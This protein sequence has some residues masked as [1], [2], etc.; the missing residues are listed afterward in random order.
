MRRSKRPTL[1]VAEL[2][3]HSSNSR[4]ISGKLLKVPQNPQF[5]DD[6]SVSDESDIIKPSKMEKQKFD[7]IEWYMKKAKE[8]SYFRC[9]KK[10]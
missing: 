4:N 2:N 8:H 6:K 9:P 5:D 3:D 7:V 1:I 10:S